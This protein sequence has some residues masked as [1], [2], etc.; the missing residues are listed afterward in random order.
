MPRRLLSGFA[1]YVYEGVFD[2]I[3]QALTSLFDTVL[4]KLAFPDDDDMPA[5]AFELLLD[6]FVPR[7]VTRELLL[8]E[9]HVALG[10]ACVLASLMLMP[11]T[12]MNEQG[13]PPAG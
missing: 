3:V 8:P 12:P 10:F 4:F 7:L 1:L 9:L 11:I 2:F 13:N 6:A 5:F